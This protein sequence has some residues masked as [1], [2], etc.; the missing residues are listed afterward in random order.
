LLRSPD[1]FAQ[2]P[3]RSTCRDLKVTQVAAL[4]ESFAAIPALCVREVNRAHATLQFSAT[5]RKM[6][7]APPVLGYTERVLLYFYQD[8]LVFII[9]VHEFDQQAAGANANR[10]YIDY[11]DSAGAFCDAPMGKL[12]VAYLQTVYARGYQYVHLWAC[13]AG[14]QWYILADPPPR[15]QHTDAELLEWYRMQFKACTGVI[16]ER[17]FFDLVDPFPVQLDGVPIFNDVFVDFLQR[18]GG[19]QVDDPKLNGN[20]GDF[21]LSTVRRFNFVYFWEFSTPDHIVPLEESTHCPTSAIFK[22]RDSFIQWQESVGGRVSDLR[23]AAHFSC[24]LVRCLLKES[25]LP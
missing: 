22:T 17:D 20:D 14:K 21:R 5:I 9:I 1:P 3:A 11:I 16:A 8:I 19:L 6:F 7:A 15:R 25:T 2:R 10:V 12:F 24:E 23:C 13:A 18:K 4:I